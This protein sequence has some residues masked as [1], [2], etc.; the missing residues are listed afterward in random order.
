MLRTQGLRDYPE[1]YVADPE[2][3]CY[4]HACSECQQEF[5]GAKGRRFNPVCKLCREVHEGFRQEAQEELVRDDAAAALAGMATREPDQ[6]D[7]FVE[8]YV[9]A[10]II[11][12][13][14][15]AQA[16]REN[17][18][19]ITTALVQS[20]AFVE[21]HRPKGWELVMGCIKDGERCRDQ[22]LLMFNKPSAT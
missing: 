15:D 19:C 10:R 7:A 21:H 2:N 1:D 11:A 3:G 6:R 20:A 5:F 16:I 18:M 4:G 17:M 22:I 13:R 14:K 12:R 9:R 8:G